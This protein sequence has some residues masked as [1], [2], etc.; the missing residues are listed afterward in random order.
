MG[1]SCN[2][3]KEGFACPSYCFFHVGPFIPD[4]DD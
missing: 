3:T 1:K 2:K 4:C